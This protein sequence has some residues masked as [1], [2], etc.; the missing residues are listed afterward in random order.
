MTGQTRP[1]LVLITGGAGYIGSVLARRLLAAGVRVRVLD[2]Q[3]FGDGL[4]GLADPGLENVRGDIRDAAAYRAALDGADVVV[5]LAAVANDPSFDLDPDL[6][7][8]INFDCLDHVM[9]LP[10][11][12]GA[13]RFVYASSA[14]VY[15]VS[16]SPDV[17]ENHPLVPITD[18]NR[19]KARGEELLFPLTAT[20]FETVAVRAATVCG[21]SPRQRLDLTV[22]ML[23]AQAV[24]NG[25]ITVFGGAQY[26]PNVHIEDLV[27]VY[28]RLVL[29]GTLGAL[30]GSALNVGNQNLPVAE[31]AEVIAARVESATGKPVAITTTESDD[32]R[33]YRL[34]SRRLRETLGITPARTV[35]DACDDVTEAIRNGDLAN[36][37]ADSRF[38]NV[39]WMKQHSGEI[40]AG[41][42]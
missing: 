18:Y 24:V 35:A 42:R 16:D 4:H 21:V 32:I 3:F 34:T 14:S 9:R 33:S 17:D 11:E 31:I 26:R 38:Y 15:G 36:P 5:H 20:G 22:N 40:G 39:R 2:A 8:S 29:D 1:Q 13:R 41:A 19:Y 37:L 12:A 27:S 6:G 10:R 7:R 30:N 23:T 28:E 25:E